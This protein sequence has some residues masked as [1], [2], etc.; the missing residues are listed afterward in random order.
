MKSQYTE[1]QSRNNVKFMQVFDKKIWNTL[2]L[3][4]DSKGITVQEYLRAVVIPEH[5]DLVKPIKVFN[6]QRSLAMKKGWETRRRN[7]EAAELETKNQTIQ[8][9]F[10]Q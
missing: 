4:A 8:A 5:L 6:K 9:V 3:R 2:K 7:Q 1:K 10:P